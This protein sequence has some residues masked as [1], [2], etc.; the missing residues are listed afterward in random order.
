MVKDKESKVKRKGLWIAV[1]L[2]AAMMLLQTTGM[3]V[4][5]DYSGPINSFTGEPTGGD[6]LSPNGDRVPIST[7]VYYDRTERLYIY[8][9]GGASGEK[10]FASVTDGM[11]VNEPVR[12]MTSQGLEVRLHCNGNLLE[13]VNLSQINTPGQYVLEARIMGEQ[14]VR[15]MNFTVVGATTGL[16]NSYPMPSG[17]VI[18]GVE[19]NVKDENGQWVPAQPVWDRSKVSMSQDGDYRVRYECAR[20][21]MSYTLQTVIDHTPPSL[22]L[23]NVVNGLAKGPVDIS[24]LE[25]GC[26]IGITL[27]G[28]KM[29]YREKLTLSGDY[30]I[31]L[32]DEAGNLT[33]YAFSILVYFDRNSWIFFG[34]VVLSIVGTGVYLYMER[35]RMRIR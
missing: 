5:L 2:L 27:N 4:D 22:A 19:L 26:K 18:T 20:N 31:I 16:I 24:D 17:F 32:Q 10:V 9:L 7:G 34:M 11:I 12:I 29:N 21:G 28:G 14:Y 6:G 1:F 15:V 30:E 13:E 33:N 8:D 23:E 35:K 3:A 25:E